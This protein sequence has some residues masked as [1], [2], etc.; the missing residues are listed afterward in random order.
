MAAKNVNMKK[1]DEKMEETAVPMFLG[2]I[3]MAKANVLRHNTFLG[4]N[5]GVIGT[6]FF[7]NF[8]VA[9]SRSN[10]EKREELKTIASSLGNLEQ[11][12]LEDETTLSFDIVPLTAIS[13]IHV[14]S[15]VK[16]KS[17]KLKPNGKKISSHY[18]QIEFRT[19]DLRVLRY[20]F[21]NVQESGRRSCFQ[22]IAHY[23]F[24]RN[25]SQLF[26]FDYGQNMRK[27]NHEKQGRA[28]CLFHHQKDYEMNLNRLNCAE[29]WRITS[30]NKEY[31]ISETLPEFNV[32]PLTLED[33]DI[34]IFSKRYNNKRFPVWLW[35]HPI[36][37]VALLLSASIETP[38]VKTGSL[39]PSL[40]V[41]KNGFADDN[42]SKKLNPIMSISHPR[43][44]MESIKSCQSTEGSGITTS[45]NVDNVCPSLNMLQESFVKLQKVCMIKSMKDYWHG[46]ST[47][48]SLIEDSKWMAYICTCLQ[49]AYNVTTT[50]KDERSSVIV[51]DATGHDFSLIVTS[52]VQIQLDP[53]YRTHIGLQA[54]IQKDWVVKGHPFNYRLRH[55]YSPTTSESKPYEA[56]S[57]ESPIFLLF[58]DCLHQLVLQFPIKFEYTE[59]FL[60]L[61]VD[62]TYSSLFATFIFNSDQQFQSSEKEV[63]LISAWD[64][65]ASNIPQSKFD[66][67]FQN[68]SYILNELKQDQLNGG[69]SS[70][71][72]DVILPHYDLSSIQFWD[73]YFFRWIDNTSLA[74]GFSTNA[75]LALQQ[76]QI[77]EE[78]N[79]LED[80]LL[81]LQNEISDS[82]S[83]FDEQ[84]RG[85]RN[86][87]NKSKRTHEKYGYSNEVTD[88]YLNLVSSFYFLKML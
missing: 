20:D 81:H 29:Q 77:L 36:T 7:T 27:G 45:V 18:D 82:P 11:M 23:A 56:K 44:V 5:V 1:K 54:L 34:E 61:L 60:I 15:A 3:V 10:A 40:R 25:V 46:D 76:H 9:F 32:C 8:K 59:H 58:I 49:L 63:N 87:S 39:K 78:V 66:L 69:T 80:R 6:L 14:L 62:C 12:F 22:T 33:E 2:E 37:G 43:K 17:K 30:I 19:K 28:F 16:Q 70:A 86:Q 57:S 42:S 84:N 68:N 31:I 13:E 4:K 65:I 79:Y 26:A 48:L 52:L 21:R 72:I 83:R 50:I 55:L 73:T 64:F 53:Y 41:A 74:K 47:W 75:M 85:K 88:E 71:G 67:L 51:N 35:S 38:L 24:P